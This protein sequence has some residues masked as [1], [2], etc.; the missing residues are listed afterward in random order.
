MNAEK[1]SLLEVCNLKT[2]PILSTWQ[3]MKGLSRLD[4]S[5]QTVHFMLT[6]VLSNTLLS[7]FTACFSGLYQPLKTLLVFQSCWYFWRKLG[8]QLVRFERIGD[9]VRYLMKPIDYILTV[10]FY[11]GKSKTLCNFIFWGLLHAACSWKYSVSKLEKK[12]FKISV[13]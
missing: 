9:E 4:S 11:I 2:N 1:W 13:K 3:S 10:Q 12:Q 6:A 5:V 7:D 8:L